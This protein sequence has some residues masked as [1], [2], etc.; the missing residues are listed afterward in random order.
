MSTRGT[1]SSEAPTS[2][3]LRVIFRP[4]VTRAQISTYASS[5]ATIEN[6]TMRASGQTFADY[7]NRQLLVSY[8]EDATAEEIAAMRDEFRDSPLVERLQE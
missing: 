8:Q 4:E 2:P 1:L 3:D 6:R 5:L 7:D